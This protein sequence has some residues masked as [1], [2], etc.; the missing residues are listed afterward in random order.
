[1]L[2]LLYFFFDI[3]VHIYGIEPS[4]PKVLSI[5]MFRSEMG[6]S[7]FIYVWFLY[8][9]LVQKRVKSKNKK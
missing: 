9:I 5:P 7:L 6:S 2:L 8:Q 1:M 4:E 3:R